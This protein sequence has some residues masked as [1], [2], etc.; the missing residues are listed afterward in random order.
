[1][2]ILYTLLTSVFVHQQTIKDGVLGHLCQEVS[3]N[4]GCL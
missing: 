3:L 2:H 1:M 4:R